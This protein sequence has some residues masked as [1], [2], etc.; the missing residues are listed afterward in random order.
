MYKDYELTVQPG[1]TAASPTEFIKTFPP[2]VIERVRVS[3]PKGPN[4]EVYIKIMHEREHV[5]PLDP[6]EWVNGEDETVTMIGPW[7]NW[8]GL[9][10]LRI[11]L[12]SPGA[13]L[14]HKVIFR[15]ELTEIGV[16]ATV[17]ELASRLTAQFLPIPD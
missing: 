8:D 17:R 11:L 15:F 7:Q 13:R 9:Y 1:V 2:C 3:F 6:Q 16:L 10:R 5:F 12:C 4:R 14:P